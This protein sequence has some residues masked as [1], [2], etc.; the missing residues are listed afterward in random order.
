MNEIALSHDEVLVKPGSCVKNPVFAA[1]DRTSI[2]GLPSSEAGRSTG[3]STEWSPASSDHESVTLVALPLRAGLPSA[4]G[5][6]P[7][8]AEP[9]RTSAAAPMMLFSVALRGT[10]VCGGPV[11]AGAATSAESASAKAP[12]GGTRD[13]P[14]A[15]P[16]APF[17]SVASSTSTAGGGASALVAAVAIALVLPAGRPTNLA[18]SG[19]T[20]RSSLDTRSTRYACSLWAYSRR[21]PLGVAIDPPNASPRRPS[22]F[23]GRCGS[24]CERMCERSAV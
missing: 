21:E 24:G 7:A 8:A 11:P 12:P 23:A 3:S 22:G 10:V 13:S 19:S 6:P 2:T 5:A 9:M 20:A 16:P 4:V 17:V 15:P 18:S 14:P 1:R